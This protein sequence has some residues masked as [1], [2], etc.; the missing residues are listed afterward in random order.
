[1]EPVRTLARKVLFWESAS[2]RWESYSSPATHTPYT[3]SCIIDGSRPRMSS[4]V[5]RDLRQ[6]EIVR[7]RW[8]LVEAIDL[9]LGRMVQR[10]QLQTA[11]DQHI[12]AWH[13]VVRWERGRLHVKRRCEPTSHNAIF[14]N[15]LDSDEFAIVP[16]EGFVIGTTVFQLDRPRDSQTESKPQS[17]SGTQFFNVED[18]RHSSFV[19]KMSTCKCC[20]LCYGNSKIGNSISMHSKF[21]SCRH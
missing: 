14:Y 13:A 8:S 6:R 11:W 10:D 9:P 18:L 1:M 15:G 17:S 7:Y 21:K 2:W 4:L 16:G 12:A 5:A 19:P 3:G 20:T